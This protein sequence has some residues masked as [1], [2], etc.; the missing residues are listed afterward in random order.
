MKYLTN[1]NRRIGNQ[2]VSYCS[3]HTALLV[4]I[5][6]PQTHLTPSKRKKTR[7]GVMAQSAK[8]LADNHE[9]L[10][11]TPPTLVEEN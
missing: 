2:M 7:A 4:P 1:T 9:D 10:G 5:N 11:S 3:T 6:S 8:C